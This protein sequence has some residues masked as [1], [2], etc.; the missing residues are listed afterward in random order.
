MDSES[1]KITSIAFESE[2]A[3]IGIN[4]FVFLPEEVLQLL[5]VQAGKDKG[6]IPVNITIE[7][8]PFTQTLVKYSGYWRLYLNTPMRKAAGKE[9]GDTAVFTIAFDP[10]PREVAIHTKLIKALDSNLEAKLV[11]NSLPPS[12]KLEIVRY[13]SFLKTED[14]IEKNV[15]KAIRFLLKKERFIGRDHP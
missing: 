8:H 15:A 7:G 4:P 10:N 2:I 12:R 5:F 9:V 14:A 1:N 13:I 3:I 11:F 6:K